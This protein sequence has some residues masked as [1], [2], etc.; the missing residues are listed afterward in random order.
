[1]AI[2]KKSAAKKAKPA[3]KAPKTKAA[4]KKK[5]KPAKKLAKKPPVKKAN[6]AKK[7]KAARKKARRNPRPPVQTL[8]PKLPLLDDGFSWP[9]FENFCVELVRRRPGVKDH[10]V[11]LYGGQGDDQK[12]IDIIAVFED[13]ERWSFQCRRVK[14]FGPANAKAVIAENEYRAD[15]N[16][17]CVASTVTAATRDVVDNKRGWDIWDALDLTSHVRALPLVDAARLIDRFFGPQWCQAI[18]GAGPARTFVPASL[19][20][21]NETDKGRLFHHLW[22]FGGREDELKKLIAFAHG[23]SGVAI[24]EGPGTIGK[25]KLLYELAR[26]I[27]AEDKDAIYFVNNGV[28]IT[29]DSVADLDRGPCTV[30]IDDAHRRDDLKAALALLGQRPHATRVLLS[31]RP[32]A[33][34]DVRAVISQ[35]G[36][37]PIEHLRLE[38]LD[39][40][41]LV[42]LAKEA[43]GAALEHYAERLATITIDSPLITV[44]GGKLLKDRAVDPQ[45][46]E[47]DA[48][49]R[50][51]VL[52]RFRDEQL[53]RLGAAVDQN[54]AR[55]ALEVIAAIA[56]LSERSPTQLE[57]LA[58][59][60]KLAEHEVRRLLEQLVQAGVL[61][62]VGRRYRIIPDVLSDHLLARAVFSEDGTATGFELAILNDFKRSCL[63]EILRNFA[64]VDWRCRA[65]AE[66]SP[67]LL[68]HLWESLAQQFQDGDHE[69][70]LSL[71]WLFGNAGYFQPELAIRFAEI[72]LTAKQAAAADAGEMSADAVRRQ[73]ATTLRYA[74][75]K[76][77]YLSCVLDL[78]W[79]L[80]RDDKRPLNMNTDHPIRVINDLAAIEVG[81]PLS[82]NSAALDAAERW[83]KEPDVGE[84]PWSPL[85]IVDRILVRN[86]MSVRSEGYQI[87]YGASV[88]NLD[89]TKD[90]RARALLM[91]RTAAES[92][93]VRVGLRAAKSLRSALQEP[94]P[95]FNQPKFDEKTR[96]AWE[97]TQHEILDV[98][99]A[100]LKAGPHVLVAEDLKDA[101]GWHVR[102]SSYDSVKKRAEQLIASIPVS[103]EARLARVLRDSWRLEDYPR[104][105]AADA[106]E[107]H[108]ARLDTECDDVV[109]ELVAA[110]PN[111][112]DGA[113]HLA[114]HMQEITAARESV[115]AWRFLGRFLTTAPEYAADVGAVILENQEAYAA[116]EPYWHVFLNAARKRD[117]AAFRAR[118]KTVLELLHRLPDGDGAAQEKKKHVAML[119]AAAFA[120]RGAGWLR[121]SADPEELVLV[122]DLAAVDDAIVRTAALQAMTA[123]AAHDEKST[124]RELIDAELHGDRELASVA[125]HTLAK[126]YELLSDDDVKGFLKKLEGVAVLDDDSI[127]EL[128]KKTA[129]SHPLDTIDCFLARIKQPSTVFDPLPFHETFHE[130]EGFRGSAHVKD[131]LARIRDAAQGAD[132]MARFHLPRLYGA[133]GR[134]APAD[135]LA[136]LREWIDKDDRE[137]V[138]RAAELA[139]DLGRHGFTT[140]NVDWVVH[141]LERALAVGGQDAYAN[142]A[143]YLAR[144]ETGGMREGEADKPFPQDVKLE[145]EAKKVAETLPAG[146]PG[147]RFYE[148]LQKEAHEEI[149]DQLDRVAEYLDEQGA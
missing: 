131:V 145:E 99:E 5:A 92:K 114:A 63:T 95:M 124:V 35:S 24:L 115:N 107:R 21:A 28:A 43:L 77:D 119:R 120:A 66:G 12:G 16:V 117:A 98:V 54:L 60:L 30:V 65:T 75:R 69:A 103:T 56:P 20:F 136:V 106:H 33:V 14:E 97:P 53:G 144:T 70:R 130:L 10:Q 64:E 42:A 91:L 73:A 100:V 101:L 51:T 127:S 34:A 81:K 13:D 141:A 72:A 116:L 32:Q 57:A 143:R 19:Y 122:R 71:L 25:S 37:T 105:D 27:D 41:R 149:T 118:I 55:R 44:V 102:R 137:L 88:V 26:A 108:E 123:M 129:G 2:K 38:R 148:R 104:G 85:E 59:H 111:A 76:I 82:F 62:K 8:R 90:L 50:G 112:K 39:K 80:S 7:A 147:R 48:D 133:V 84:H 46:L 22:S 3:K 121:A 142:V 93:D 47:R 146:S 17:I 138:E 31:T 140:K 89:V 18:L 126:H 128:M 1:M 6:P 87:N 67:P 4:A 45:L 36:Q 94:L 86:L 135:A 9:E 58:K 61:L 79:K 96:A 68:D 15:H 134:T 29:P 132:A 40:Q 113:A 83:L 23:K 49:F 78:L 110:H 11:H 125:A 52:D 109:K 74:G 139:S